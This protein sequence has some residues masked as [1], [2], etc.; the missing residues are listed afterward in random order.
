[1]KSNVRKELTPKNIFLAERC[2]NFYLLTTN[3]TFNEN[4]CNNICH[5]L[6]IIAIVLITRS[7]LENTRC[8]IFR[9]VRK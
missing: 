4:N 5:S 8:H 2:I 7:R 3:A 6:T 9:C 1:M